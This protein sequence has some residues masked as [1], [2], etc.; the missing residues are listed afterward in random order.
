MFIATS[1]DDHDKEKRT[2]ENLLVRSGESE[3]EVTG[4]DVLYSRSY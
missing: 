2:E 4:L 1:M 3:A